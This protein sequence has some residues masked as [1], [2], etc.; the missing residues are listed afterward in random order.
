VETVGQQPEILKISRGVAS[1][2]ID[3]HFAVLGVAI[4][5]DVTQMRKKFLRLAKV[6]HPDVANYS[7][8]EKELATNYFA[9][10]VSPAY[11]VLNSDRDRAEYLLTLRTL[12]QGFKQKPPQV[13]L[14]SAAARQFLQYPNEG[15]YIKGI[16][17]IAGLQYSNLDKVLDY[18]AE[19]SELNLVYLMTQDMS[20]QSSGSREYDSSA[21]EVQ[22]PNVIK[23]QSGIQLAEMYIGKKQWSEAMRELKVLEKLAA[24]NAKVH[25]L[26]GL[27]YMNQNLAVMAKTSFQKALKLDPKNAIALKYLNQS[28]SAQPQAGKQSVAQ[29]GKQSPKQSPKQDDK[30]GGWFGW[31]KK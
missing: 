22:D 5:T 1:Y 6:L 26:I 27:V 16:N 29:S 13:E 23:I 19:L 14:Q 9:K 30:K 11:Q 20:G 15:N 18:T 10:L 25:A 31:G 7:D 21:R 2:K 4:N 28:G 17:E 24:D 3:D 8:A 12:A